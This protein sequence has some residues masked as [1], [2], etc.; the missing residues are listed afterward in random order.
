M[1]GTGTQKDYLYDLE[2]GKSVVGDTN[3]IRETE[4]YF[5]ANP[6]A[7]TSEHVLYILPSFDLTPE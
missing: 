6:G 5:A 3:I 1:Y 2:D 7:K 4:A